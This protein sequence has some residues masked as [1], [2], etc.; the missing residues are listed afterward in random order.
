MEISNFFHFTNWKTLYKCSKR[1]SSVLIKKQHMTKLEYNDINMNL[2]IF[3]DNNGVFSP[4]K[5][6]FSSFVS[7]FKLANIIQMFQTVLKCLNWKQHMTRLKYIITIS[8]IGG[9][10]PTFGE[11]FPTEREIPQ[12]HTQ[13]GYTSN[14]NDIDVVRME[15]FCH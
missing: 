7:F 3:P 10:F 6:K 1:Y 8:Q 15:V 14:S 13:T 5:W 11:I 4:Q 2:G 9:M 12:S